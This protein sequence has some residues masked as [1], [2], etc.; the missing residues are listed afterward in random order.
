M[1]PHRFQGE[2]ICEPLLRG[3]Y[4]GVVFCPNQVTAAI[5]LGMALHN[6][7]MAET[8]VIYWPDRCDVS[9]LRAARVR[10]WSY[11]RVR[12]LWYL[13]CLMLIRI[14]VSVEVCLPHRK[15][16][17]MVEWFARLCSTT[18]IVDDG[19]DAWREQPQN[20]DPATFALGANFY[21]F[22]YSTPLGHWLQRFTLCPIIG[23]EAMAEVARD[24]LNL[25]S[26]RRLVVESPPLGR[27]VDELELDKDGVMLVAHSNVNKRLILGDVPRVVQGGEWALERS[28]RAYTG[29]IIVG[30]SMIAVYAL[31]QSN[32]AYRLLIYIAQENK[33][34]LAPLIHLIEQR[35]F[36]T[37]REC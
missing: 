5:A 3:K 16:G 26:V 20:I 32:P 18:S 12:G 31:L 22:Q 14:F 30:E 8:L 4:K 23:I 19:L 13:A 11:N 27:V 24:M 25:D 33:S 36:S 9:S 34:N 10:C 29:E 6:D 21:T 35:S 15:L 2:A 37:L 28:I 1:T 7:S 17:R